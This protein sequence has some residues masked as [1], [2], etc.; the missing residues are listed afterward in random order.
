MDLLASLLRE[1]APQLVSAVTE[2]TDLTSEQ[3]ERL[4]PE[5]ADAT[6]AALG[7]SEGLDLGNLLGGGNLGQLLS[8]IDVSALASRVG[9]SDSQ[10]G[11]ALQTIVPLV[12]QLIQSKGGGADGV[13]SLIGGKGTGGLLSQVGQ[14]AGKL[15]KK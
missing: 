7:Q 6:V 4:V 2:K 14:L 11:T 9:I 10:A 1:Q 13:T 8:K 15:F 5:A 3:A 12:L